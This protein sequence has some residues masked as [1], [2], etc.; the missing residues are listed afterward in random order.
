MGA[1]QYNLTK[2]AYTMN[3]L[4]TL[5]VVRSRTTAYRLIG[6]GKLRLTKQRSRSV[7]LISD[8]VAFLDSLKSEAA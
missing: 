1:S 6:E 5:G 7:F 2:T 8:V 3:E 4:I